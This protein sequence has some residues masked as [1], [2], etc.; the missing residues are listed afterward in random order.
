M[1]YVGRRPLAFAI[2]AY[3][4]FVSGKGPMRRVCCT[5][6]T[7]ESCS[8]YGLRVT[9][10][11][12]TSLPHAFGLVR[13]RIRACR[14]MSIYRFREGLGWE[15]DHERAPAELVALL[16]A[17]GE[18]AD[19]IAQVMAAR[20]AVAKWRGERA[21]LAAARPIAAA[22][23]HRVGVRAGD[24]AIARHRQATL[25]GATFAVL[26]MMLA[27]VSLWAIVPMLFS[28]AAAASARGAAL[29]LEQQRVAARFLRPAAS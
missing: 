10:D 23:K 21:E 6:A 11:L 27:T 19:T 4:R 14:T 5:F 28:V 16:E 22:A 3:R 20:T 7:T 2:R 8:A 24:A 29:R 25:R 15:R 1:T 9:E 18:R 12:A 17:R 26:A 13:A